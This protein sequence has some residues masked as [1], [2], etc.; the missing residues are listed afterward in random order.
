MVRVSYLLFFVR[1]CFCEPLLAENTNNMKNP[2]Q[3]DSK[4]ERQKQRKCLAVILTLFSSFSFVWKAENCTVF[5]TGVITTWFIT[6]TE[7]GIP[8]PMPVTLDCDYLYRTSH[9]HLICQRHFL[10]SLATCCI[11]WWKTSHL[12]FRECILYA[13]YSLLCPITKAR[14]NQRSPQS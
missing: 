12:E 11:C 2:E 4:E 6:Y 9:S 3:N 13:S 7:D 1:K 10:T 5:R 14:G 8:V